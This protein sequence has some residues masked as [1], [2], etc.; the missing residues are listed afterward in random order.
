MRDQWYVQNGNRVAGPFSRRQLAALAQQGKLKPH[1]LIRNGQQG[2]WQPVSGVSG[3]LPA[4]RP[5]PSPNE[6]S[7]TPEKPS[8][9]PSPTLSPI[10][11]VGLIGGAV[12]LS[13]AA[14][15]VVCVM[16]L[17]RPSGDENPGQPPP[18]VE[19]SAP[20]PESESF[21][22]QPERERNDV[23]AAPAEPAAGPAQAPA[24]ARV[25]AAPAEPA[26][27]NVTAEKTRP[28]EKQKPLAKPPAKVVTEVQPLLPPIPEEKV[29]ISDAEIRKFERGVKLERRAVHACARYEVFAQSFAFTP[30]QQTEIDSTLDEWKKRSEADL[31]RLGS[32]WVPREEVVAAEQSAE[33][34]IQRAVALI[35]VGN[36]DGCI[37][38]LED[39]NRENPNGIKAPFLLGLIWSLPFAGLN[40]PDN[41]EKYFRVVL[42]RH[43]NHPA[44]LNS[45]ALAQIKQGD[46]NAAFRN[47]EEAASLADVCPEVVQNLGR[48]IRLAESGRIKTTSATL[49]RYSDLYSE[50]IATKR[51]PEFNDR[52]GWLHMLPVF[53]TAE[54]EESAE[55]SAAHVG[56]G[57]EKLV[58]MF[59]GSGFVVA[60][61]YVM[62]NRHVAV[63]ENLGVADT[64]GIPDPANPK[65]ELHGTVVAVSDEVDLALIHFP[66]LTAKPLPLHPQKID[67][68]SDVL[69]LGFP[70]GDVLGT[71]MKATQ[72]VITGLPDATR[73]GELGRYYIFDATSDQG[74]SGGPVFDRTG[75]VVGVLTFL[76]REGAS[77]VSQGVVS[78]GIDAELS[79]GVT[80]ESA[81]AFANQHIARFA[82]QAAPDAAKFDDW[83]QLTRSVSPSVFRLT[84]YYRAGLPQLQVAADLGQVKRSA[85][86]DYTCPRCN[87]G[88]RL[89]CPQRGCQRGEVSVKY[90]DSKV[91]G[92]GTNRT[93]MR[94]P[95]YRKERCPRCEGKASL[96]CPDCVIGI[97]TTL[98]R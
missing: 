40:G 54:R 94:V 6:K 78:Q 2:E 71:G 72:G 17:T 88:S 38:Q 30:E 48:F 31:Y 89:P 34:L 41:A 3:L 91:I 56:K 79:G 12:F 11:L 68:A 35:E 13:T 8:A 1:N 69:I 26:S 74:N 18:V 62:T 75:R 92:V 83:A 10:M 51:G 36:F 9:E 93:V 82:E 98:L 5:G 55:T 49:R 19:D 44:A 73:Q 24:P 50:L 86:E 85:M 20:E 25:A 52:L 39:A 16:L 96:D 67:L 37:E 66:K 47:L 95:R 4:G 43:P 58:P 60:P 90:F 29:A 80:S 59:S 27:P 70:R 57:G 22:P 15:A 76:Y 14:T 33:Q 42:L 7:G 53:P 81:H 61:G 87:G 28:A 77:I 63:D 46:H 64:I 84:V 32:D 23:T 45:M 65:N 97:D 21:L